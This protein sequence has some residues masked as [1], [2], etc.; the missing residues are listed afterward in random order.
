MRW[1]VWSAIL[2]IT[3]VAG[4]AVGYSG[5]GRD[6]LKA[7]FQRLPAEL[8][9]SGLG[10][11]SDSSLVYSTYAGITG[12]D[13]YASRQGESMFAAVPRIPGL[14][15]DGVSDLISLRAAGDVADRRRRLV[16]E[17]WGWPDLSTTARPDHVATGAVDPEFTGLPDLESIDRL[18]IGLAYE[19]RSVAY[20]FH[21]RRPNGGLVIF[22][23]GHEDE[24]FVSGRAEIGRFLAEGYSVLALAMPLKGL[25]MPDPPFIDHPRFGPMQVTGNHNMF[26][27]LEDDRY[28][29]LHLFLHPVLASVNYLEERYDYRSLAMVGLSGGGWVTTVY[30]ALDPRIERSFPVAGTLPFH[31]RAVEPRLGWGDW[32]QSMSP[33]YRQVNYLDLYVL[34]GAGH[35]R[36][37]VQILNQYDSCCFAGIGARSYVSAVSDRIDELDQ[38]GDFDLVIDDSH[39]GHSISDAALTLILADLEGVLPDR[40]HR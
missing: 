25:N 28:S 31:L 24:G 10:I 30:S 21:A 15:P 39:V 23:S 29:P 26:A 34:G 35:G 19:L 20:H 13:A 12:Y 6:A 3:F 4:L 7:A 37:Q 8:P 33:I 14:G 11:P 36:R 32:E 1:V 22:H 18:E 16:A 2:S 17:I 9:G 5:H 40:G 38:G 27:L